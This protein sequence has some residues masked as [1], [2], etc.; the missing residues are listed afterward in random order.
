M[1]GWFVK[2]RG[3]GVTPAATESHAATLYLARKRGD[4]IRIHDE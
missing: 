1:E 3:G 2:V 4:D